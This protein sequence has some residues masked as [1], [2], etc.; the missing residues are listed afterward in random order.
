MFNSLGSSAEKYL[1]QQK[2][3]Q[4][5]EESKDILYELEQLHGQFIDK[6]M[7]HDFFSF[8]SRVVLSRKKTFSTVTPEKLMQ[9]QSYELEKPLTIGQ[10]PQEEKTIKNI[11]VHMLK[12]AQEVKSSQAPVWHAQEIVRLAKESSVLIRNEVQ[13]LLIKQIHK[14]E[15]KSLVLYLQLNSLFCSCIQISVEFL[16]PSL[17]FFYQLAKSEKLACIQSHCK[18]YLKRACRCL[19]FPPSQLPNDDEALRIMNLKALTVSIEVYNKNMLWVEVDPSSSIGQVVQE[20][21]QQL[22]TDLDLQL[23]LVQQAGSNVEEEYLEQ[24]HKVESPPI[25]CS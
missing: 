8:A 22:D 2:V 4:G 5:L 15:T 1:L 10:F 3:S 14:N 17:N 7:E 16:L 9:H 11:F 21:K 24:G 20:S 18:L 13:M 12:F 6:I 25:Y 19:E 23:V